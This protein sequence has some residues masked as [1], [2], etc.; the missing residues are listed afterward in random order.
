[1]PPLSWSLLANPL[2]SGTGLFRLLNA[3]SW[4]LWWLRMMGEGVRKTGGP[5]GGL[6]GE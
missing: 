5:E 6:V 3:D 2:G 4:S 1:M